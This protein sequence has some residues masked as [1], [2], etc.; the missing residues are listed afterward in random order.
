MQTGPACGKGP[1][2]LDLEFGLGGSVREGCVEMWRQCGLENQEE[3]LG[4]EGGGLA[5][6][7]FVV[8]THTGQEL[9][10]YPLSC[11]MCSVGLGDLGPGRTSV[12]APSRDSP[13]CFSRSYKGPACLEHV[14]PAA[15]PWGV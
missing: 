15:C 9:R 1:V 2:T 7:Q 8:H 6:C 3:F 12:P 11:D 4:R 13:S 14:E 5:A 10:Q